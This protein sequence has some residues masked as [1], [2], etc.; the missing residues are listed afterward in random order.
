MQ[1]ISA[2]KTDEF[3]G[4]SILETLQFWAQQHPNQN[5]LVHLADGE[6]ISTEVTYAQLML[7]IGALAKQ[8]LQHTQPGERAVLCIDN[9]AEFLLALLACFRARII[10]I[11]SLTP[12]NERAIKRIEAHLLDSKAAVVLLDNQAAKQLSMKRYQGALTE[13]LCLNINAMPD[14][15]ASTQTLNP[16]PLAS[17]EIAY[18]QYTSG[19]TMNPRGVM[20]THGNLTAQQQMLRQKLN[21]PPQCVIVNWMPLHHDFGLVMSLQAICTGGCCVLLPPVRVVQQPIRWLWAIDRFRATLSAGATFMF[22]LCTRKVRPEQCSDLDLSHW[23]QVIIAAE[24]IHADIV[25]NFSAKFKSYGFK[26]S[27]FWPAYGMAEAT[28]LIT[29]KNGVEPVIRRFDTNALQ[30]KH[31]IANEIGQ[32]LVGSGQLCFPESVL[33]VDPETFSPS[34]ADKIGELW[35]KNPCVGKGYWQQ[36]QAT[37]ATF[38]AYLANSTEGPYLRTGDLAFMH[39]QEVFIA[40]RLKDTLIINGEN[41]YPQDIEWTVNSCHP[42]LEP[43]AGVALGIDIQGVER[44]AIVYEIKRTARNGLDINEVAS[45]IRAAVVKQQEID[46][47]M[48]VLLQ[49]A[50]LPKTSSGK[51]QRQTCKQRLLANGLETVA[52]W[53]PTTTPQSIAQTSTDSNTLLQLCQTI[54]NEPNIGLNDDLFA[55]GADSIKSTEL[56]AEIEAR[57]QC[58]IDLIQFNKLPTVNSLLAMLPDTGASKNELPSE[59]HPVKAQQAASAPFYFRQLSDHHLHSLLAYTSAW[60]AEWVSPNRLVFGLNLQGTKPPLFWCCQGFHEFSQLA[61]YLGPDQPLY[62]LRSGYLVMDYTD[63][64][65]ITALASRYMEEILSAIPQDFYLLGANCQAGLVLLRIAQMLAGLGEQVQQLFILENIAPRVNPCVLPF[66]IALFY[67]RHSTNVNPYLQFPAPDSAWQ[68]LYPLGHSIDIINGDHGQ[69]FDEPAIS[70]FANKLAMRLQ[71]S[72]ANPTQGALPEAAYSAMIDPFIPAQIKWQAGATVV[73][74]LR[75]KNTSPLSWAAHSGLIAA[76][77]W[78]DSTEQPLQWLDGYVPITET[79]LPGQ[80]LT[81]MLPVTLPPQHGACFLEI[82]LAEQGIAWFKE[83]GNTP[84]RLA[85]TVVEACPTQP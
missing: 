45:A 71:E 4:S 60:Q 67:G 23:Q 58:D 50:S 1:S 42:A 19:S 44:L 34:P 10:A 20:I 18:L 46:V 31:V 40:G 17:D 13:A 14:I 28:L 38:D 29:L 66:K 57:W 15:P 12:N 36:P 27:A 5:A 56:I 75:I 76:N 16:Q 64:G 74:T 43:G 8:L 51:V 72:A 37:Q 49:P 9:E 33:I 70:D 73:I 25:Q 2:K 39:Q 32:P 41:R 30:Q 85:V 65:A 61:R 79:V 81:V 54:L 52:V 26:R 35:V 48:V 24:P 83:K 62:G 77:H 47:H 78:L 7:R 69:F 68:K 3:Y 55:H 82:D 80:V 63:K 11:P 21:Q 84:Y 22:D 59:T 53:P 6:N